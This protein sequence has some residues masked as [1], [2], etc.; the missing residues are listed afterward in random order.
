MRICSVEGCEKKHYAKGYC[1]AHHQQVWLHGHVKNNYVRKNA[2]DV[3]LYGNYAELILRN[4]NGEETGRALID[5]D[6]LEL[7]TQYTWCL[8]T[9]GYAR[10][11][12]KGKTLYLHRIVLGLDDTDN[13]VDHVNRNK[14]DDRKANLRECAHW[15]NASNRG[16]VTGG[17]CD[18]K[19]NLTKPFKADVIRNGTKYNL[20]YF[21]TKE[22]AL[23]TRLKAQEQIDKSLGITL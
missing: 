17:V 1:R 3:I 9:N 20:G 10:C 21:A 19:R 11:T 13:E 18:T 6:D 15:V 7:V 16:L 23:T 8:H 4:A 2:N 12:R 14:L 22:E 5:S